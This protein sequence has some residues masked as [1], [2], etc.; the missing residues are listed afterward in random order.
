MYNYVVI[1]S[2]S[3]NIQEAKDQGKILNALNG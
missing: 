1:D 2:E 3:T